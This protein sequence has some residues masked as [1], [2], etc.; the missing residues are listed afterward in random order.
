MRVLNA[1]LALLLLLLAAVNAAQWLPAGAS[2]KQATQSLMVQECVWVKARV[3]N[4]SWE[5]CTYPAHFD[6]HLS[7]VIQQHACVECDDVAF[8]LTQLAS[9]RG[10]ETRSRGPPPMLIDLGANSEQQRKV[11]VSNSGHYFWVTA[12]SLTDIPPHLPT[13]GNSSQYSRHVLACGG[14]G[15]QRRHLL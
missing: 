6:R 13:S 2:L 12:W 11:H 14:S 1:R 15:R 8:T 7:R 3:G 5:M 9:G 4:A 10:R